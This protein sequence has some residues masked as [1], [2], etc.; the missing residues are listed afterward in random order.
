[1]TDSAQQIVK[2]LSKVYVDNVRRNPVYSSRS[3]FDDACIKLIDRAKALI[4]ADSL[5]RK[6]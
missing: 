2:E 6:L 4:P 5:E 1:M 3:E